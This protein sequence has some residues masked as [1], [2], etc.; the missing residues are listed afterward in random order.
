[1]T[2]IRRYSEIT[3]KLERFQPITFNALVSYFNIQELRAVSLSFLPF[4]HLSLACSYFFFL[5]Q[6]PI[7]VRYVKLLLNV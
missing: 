3:A 4:A 6:S 5:R 1:M 2:Y 7:V